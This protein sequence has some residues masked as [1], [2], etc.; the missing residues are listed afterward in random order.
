MIDATGDTADPRIAL[1]PPCLGL[2]LSSAV[3]NLTVLNAHTGSSTP[4][5]EAVTLITVCALAAILIVATISCGRLGKRAVS[6]TTFLAVHASGITAL[7][8]TFLDTMGSAPT[9]LVVMPLEALCCAGS[10]LLGF[11]WLRKMR[12]TSSAAVAQVALAALAL[13]ELITFAL[14]F[15]DAV[16]HGGAFALSFIQFGLV[17]WSR[18]VGVPSDGHPAV[19]E[20]YFGT[21]EHRFSSR[22]YLA[23]A[24]LGICL[25]AIP[26]GMGATFPAG[27]SAA[28]GLAER[29]AIPIAC[30][31]AALLCGRELDRHPDRGGATAIWF[32]MGVLL[33]LGMVLLS[34]G[35]A[36]RSWGGV[37][38]TLAALALRGFVWYLSV[39]FVSFGARDP[40][41]YTTIT[42]TAM[43]VLTVAGMGAS[44]LIG[45]IA[46]GREGLPIAV[47]ATFLIASIYVVLTQLLGD[48]ERAAQPGS[49]AVDASDPAAETASATDPTTG[50]E[51]GQAAPADPPLM[52]IMGVPPETENSLPSATPDVHIATSVIEMGQRFGL[53]GREIEVLTLYALGHTQARVSEELQLSTNT[54]HTHIKRIYDKT[55]LHSRQEILDYI[56]QYG[57]SV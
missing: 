52:K 26:C 15:G 6:L 1:V 46:P 12:G 7:A 3:F 38:C 8:L 33:C 44:A 17:R 27:S 10:A 35:D 45:R 25:I 43:N 19:S 41:F 31:G 57:R 2:A 32:G 36:A 14:G 11:Y 51:S 22:G 42:W 29:A 39:A 16:R 50:D 30:A 21:G 47:M 48:T 23:A 37:A 24:A 53:T 56:S 54:V 13:G 49:A 18:E 4:S 28:F 9:G 34:A 40:Y 5:L 20:T 55:D